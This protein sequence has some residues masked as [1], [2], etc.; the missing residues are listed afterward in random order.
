[1]ILGIGV[2]I[3]EVGRM[4]RAL[5]R[6]GQRLEQRVFTPAERSDCAG[7]ADQDL[8]LAA[9][10]AAKE[11]CLKALGTGW[12]E[13]LSF[14][15]VEVNRGRDGRPTLRLHGAAAA[16]A[17]RRGVTATHVSL[18]H[19]PSVAVAVVVL[20]GGAGSGR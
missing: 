19:Q 12:A 3:V 5:K 13:G 18:S 1:M 20:E 10:F 15:Q 9:R 2:D 8:A 11:A 16:L 14:R 4:R 17:D 7:R 6:H